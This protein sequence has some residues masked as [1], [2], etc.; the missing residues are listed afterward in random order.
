[1][2]QFCTADFTCHRLRKPDWQMLYR[3][4]LI[5]RNSQSILLTQWIIRWHRNLSCVDPS[6]ALTDIHSNSPCTNN[7]ADNS[8][9]RRCLS[10]SSTLRLVSSHS[11]R[12]KTVG[13]TGQI[14]HVQLLFYERHEYW[15]AEASMNL[16]YCCFCYC[17]VLF[18]DFILLKVRLSC[19]EILSR[20]YEWVN[21]RV[22][23]EP[24]TCLLR[25]CCIM[26]NILKKNLLRRSS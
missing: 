11:L 26:R 24:A 8:T 1:L 20:L 16:F 15:L 3:Y 22:T 13:T 25:Y 4:G 17:P 19:G 6:T 14:L 7:D 5:H 10:L 2:F 21:I 18:H 9:A 23:N 12:C